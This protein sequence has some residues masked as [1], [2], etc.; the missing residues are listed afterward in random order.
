MDDD[1]SAM[2]TGCGRAATLGLDRGRPA[3]I[4]GLASVGAGAIHLAAAG[5]H[6]EHPTLARHL[7]R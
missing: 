6:A 7:R 2:A 5:I 3:Q 4:A 1:G